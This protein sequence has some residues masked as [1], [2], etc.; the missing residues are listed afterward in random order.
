MLSGYKCLVLL[1]FLLAAESLSAQ[2][3]FFGIGMPY[4]AYHHSTTERYY[5][6]PALFGYDVQVVKKKQ[7]EF[8]LNLPTLNVLV[9]VE[10]GRWRFTTEPTVQPLNFAY[11]FYYPTG[12]GQIRTPDANLDKEDFHTSMLGLSVPV[13]AHYAVWN[14]RY[15]DQ[16]LFLQAGASYF[17]N[18]SKDDFRNIYY[19][20]MYAWAVGGLSYQTGGMYRANFYVRYN[21]LLNPTNVAEMKIGAVMVGWAAH[22]PS[23]QVQRKKLYSDD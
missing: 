12:N 23:I 3:L 4:Q 10:Y 17:Q 22:F 6:L 11:R 7:S 21:L 13:L 8:G 19:Q 9:G 18:F 1:A 14:S 15:K 20:S 16:N 2:R 5:V